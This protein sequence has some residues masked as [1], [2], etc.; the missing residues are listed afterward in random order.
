MGTNSTTAPAAESA[1]TINPTIE[2]LRY[3]KP[4]RTGH[5]TGWA[6]DWFR[7]WSGRVGTVYISDTGELVL[8]YCPERDSTE[9]DALRSRL[10]EQ[11][12]GVADVIAAVDR[13]CRAWDALVAES[14]QRQRAQAEG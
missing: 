11:A 7:K 6:I 2:R 10:E 1:V 8:L 4:R 9:R 3:P 12:H 14:N 13:A 5:P